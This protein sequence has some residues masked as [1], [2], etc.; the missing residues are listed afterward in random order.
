MRK[1][2]LLGL[3]AVFAL[4]A[5][6]RESASPDVR[7][8]GLTGDVRE[9]YFSVV[10]SDPDDPMDE[11]SYLAFDARGRVTL[12]PFGNVYTY[13]AEGN[14]DGAYKEFITVERDTRGRLVTFDNSEVIE[15]DFDDFDVMDICHLEFEYDDLGRT[16]TIHYNGWEWGTTYLSTYEGKNV[17][18]VREVTESYDE[19]YNETTTTTYEYLEFDA[20]GNWT[21][22]TA[23]ATTKSW[24]EEDEESEESYTTVIRQIRRI[25]Y[26]SD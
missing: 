20:K 3:A 15:E 24:E 21:S 17:W 10:S 22:R 7:T 26:W 23:T 19:G 14:Y 2:L 4:M 5:C 25:T 12:D 16:T 11:I 13:D 6:Q 18:P 9:V 8:F 1:S